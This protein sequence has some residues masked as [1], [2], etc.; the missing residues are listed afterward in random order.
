METIYEARGGAQTA[1]NNPLIF[2]SS[3]STRDSYNV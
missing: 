1:L 3:F 2:Y